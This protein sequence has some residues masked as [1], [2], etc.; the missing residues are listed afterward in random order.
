MCSIIQNVAS[1]KVFWKLLGNLIL[2][3]NRHKFGK[4]NPGEAGWKAGDGSRF[5][6]LYMEKKTGSKELIRM[7]EIWGKAM[8]VCGWTGGIRQKKEAIEN[9]RHFE[10]REGIKEN[11]RKE[12]FYYRIIIRFRFVNFWIFLSRRGIRNIR[13]KN[14]SS[15]FL[16]ILEK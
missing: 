14:N 1:L 9:R 15:V 10:A 8:K 16:K 11:N 5:R 12:E 7:I 4:T 13:D 2:L 3:Q 6:M